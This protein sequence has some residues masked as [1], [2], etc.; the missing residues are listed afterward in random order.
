METFLKWSTKMILTAV[1]AQELGEALLDASNNLTN[2]DTAQ[3]VILLNDKAISVPT[4]DH[5][6]DWPTVA[7][8]K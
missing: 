3:S 6:D 1:E 5:I 7:Y 4:G 8:V 2:T